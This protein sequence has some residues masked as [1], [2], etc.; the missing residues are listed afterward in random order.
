MSGFN[1]ASV[2]GAES[3]IAAIMLKEIFMLIAGPVNRELWVKLRHQ[4]HLVAEHFLYNNPCSN[5]K[6]L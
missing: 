1:G 2:L 5:L 4:M 6:C 3:N